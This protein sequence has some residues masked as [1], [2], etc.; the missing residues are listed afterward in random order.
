MY[1]KRIELN[2]SLVDLIQTFI[3]AQVCVVV[4]VQITVI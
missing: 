3:P 4:H 1:Y 2:I